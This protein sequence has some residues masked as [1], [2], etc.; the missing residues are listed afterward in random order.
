MGC[1]PC[2]LVAKWVNPVLKS[3][4]PLR[5]RND[6]RRAALLQVPGPPF[7][8]EHVGIAG[9]DIAGGRLW[10][11]ASRRGDIAGD[12]RLL[13]EALHGFWGGLLLKL[14]LTLG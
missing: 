3:N 13:R 11:G 4:V 2:S 9:G 7:V 12:C 14:L 5:D 6:I 8:H 10:G 1:S